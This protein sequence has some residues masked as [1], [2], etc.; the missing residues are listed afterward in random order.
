MNKIVFGLGLSLFS[1]STYANSLNV[2]SISTS[3]PQ[4]QSTI[5]FENDTLKNDQN[6]GVK[7]TVL[8]DADISNKLVP[9]NLTITHIQIGNRKERCIVNIYPN[10]PIELKQ[11][12]ATLTPVLGSYNIDNNTIFGDIDYSYIP[13]KTN[14]FARI[15]FKEM[16]VN[17]CHIPAISDAILGV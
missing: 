10:Q 12:Y 17:G 15:S 9:V 16:N 4:I 2:S 13:G 8:S 11:P 3:S 7:M 14:S 5:A 6:I 1:L